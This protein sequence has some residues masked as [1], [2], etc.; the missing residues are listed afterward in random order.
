[1]VLSKLSEI[2]KTPCG[3]KTINCKVLEK[4]TQTSFTIGDNTGFCHLEICEDIQKI[5]RY[6]MVGKFV[7]IANCT[8]D[9][10]TSTIKC[11]KNSFVFIGR[12]IDNVKCPDSPKTIDYKDLSH[13]YQMNAYE[14]VKVAL[15]AKVVDLKSLKV[16]T[17]YGKKSVRKLTLKDVNGNTNVV[18]IWNSKFKEVD[19]GLVYIFRGLRV[20]NYPAEKPHH[21]QTKEGTYIQL[22]DLQMQQTF[23]TVDLPDGILK[24]VSIIGVQDFHHYDACSNCHGSMR[25]SEDNQCIKCDEVMEKPNRDFKFCLVVCTGSDEE[26]E[27][28]IGFKRNLGVEIL[29][30]DQVEEQ[31]VEMK[32]NEVLVGKMVTF[33]FTNTHGLEKEDDRNVKTLLYLKVDE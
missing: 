21:L 8:Y 9:E 26:L 16:R 29:A 23:K 17:R 32:L 7:K 25:Q 15:L 19:Q 10:S 2:F 18:S 24:H 1:M 22:A 14:E 12:S 30:F 28:F 20:E 6:L 27:S 3:M 11:V 5:T 13:T 33:A 4:H 31:D